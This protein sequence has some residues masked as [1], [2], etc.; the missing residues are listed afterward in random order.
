[1]LEHWSPAAAADLIE[2]LPVERQVVALWSVFSDLYGPHWPL[3][4]L[5]VGT[6]LVGIVL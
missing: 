5:T 6:A 3:A 4:A 1:M 2:A